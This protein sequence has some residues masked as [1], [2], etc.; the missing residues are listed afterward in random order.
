MSHAVGPTAVPAAQPATS[1][2]AA[3][4]PVYGPI[5][6]EEYVVQR[7]LDREDEPEEYPEALGG[8]A[9]SVGP[10]QPVNTDLEF[11]ELFSFFPV[12]P[13]F[14]R[15]PAFTLP[16]VMQRSPN[17]ALAAAEALIQ[18]HI[19]VWAQ[20]Y[21][22]AHI[23][24]SSHAEA[25]LAAMSPIYPFHRRWVIYAASFRLGWLSEVYIMIVQPGVPPPRTPIGSLQVRRDL[26]LSPS[27]QGVVAPASP[28]ADIPALRVIIPTVMYVA[29]LNAA[30]AELSTL[31]H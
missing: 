12:S 22:D 27:V 28:T 7:A 31:P 2:A 4:G 19:P 23:P 9:M 20:M 15:D 11:G 6:S 10:P 26:Y 25:F 30:A 5:T 14:D 24:G 21:V 18:Y 3:L 16:A 1:T 8:V 13:L 17:V 29:C